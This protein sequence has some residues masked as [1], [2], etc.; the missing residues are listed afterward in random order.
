MRTSMLPLVDIVRGC[1]LHADEAVDTALTS[2]TDVFNFYS[3]DLVAD[4][5]HA[6]MIG[7]TRYALNYSTLKLKS[8]MKIGSFVPIAVINHKYKSH[9][10]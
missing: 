7:E 8:S 9:L 6:L 3:R 4:S 10:K 5:R 2:I 1:R